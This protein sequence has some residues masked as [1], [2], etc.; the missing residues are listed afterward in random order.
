[1][2]RIKTVIIVFFLSNRRE[3]FTDF[4]NERVENSKL[5]SEIDLNLIIGD[6]RDRR[7]FEYGK[8]VMCTINKTIWYSQVYPQYYRGLSTWFFEMQNLFF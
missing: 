4:S 6:Y 7:N 5:Y 3:S 1:M 8:C 2:C